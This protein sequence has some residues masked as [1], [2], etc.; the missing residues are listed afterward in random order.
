MSALDLV[1]HVIEQSTPYRAPQAARPVDADVVVDIKP[2]VCW[3]CKQPASGG[4]ATVAVRTCGSP[5]C[6]AK[7]KARTTEREKAAANEISLRGT[8]RHRP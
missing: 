4:F 6:R 1:M 2:A 5:E 3:F 7:R 8:Y